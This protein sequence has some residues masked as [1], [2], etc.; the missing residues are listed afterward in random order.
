MYKRQVL[1]NGFT[2]YQRGFGG[3][4]R[5][6]VYSL[7]GASQWVTNGITNYA[8]PQVAPEESFG[9]MA[10]AVYQFFLNGGTQAYIVGLLPQTPLPL[11]PG[12][13]SS[14]T[15]GTVAP[16]GLNITF[17]ARE[18]TDTN[19]VMTLTLRPIASAPTS[20]PS[21]SQQAD[22]IITLSLIHI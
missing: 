14:V 7:S 3:F 15:A 10:S 9:D 6:T 5:S 4:L 17:T 11:G 8:D 20:L 18:V 21:S 19:F 2:D 1:I 22:V 12:G 16:N 13:T